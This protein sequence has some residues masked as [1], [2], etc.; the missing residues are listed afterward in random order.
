MTERKTPG[1]KAGLV[2]CP[3]FELGLL[4]IKSEPVNW[5]SSGCRH[6]YQ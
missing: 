5:P 1:D 2:F 3:G 4:L 6:A